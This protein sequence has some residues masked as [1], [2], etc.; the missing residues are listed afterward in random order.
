MILIA[1]PCVIENENIIFR[2]CDFLVKLTDKYK[3]EL[4]FKS[5]YDK[6]NRSSIN[7]FRGPGIEVGYKIFEKLKREFDVKI[8][9]DVH[10]DSEV[11]IIK[12]VVDIIQIPAFLCRQTDLLKTAAD[13]KKIINVKKGQFMAPW[14]MKDVIEKLKYFNAIDILITERGFTFGYNNLVV[15][16]RSFPILKSFGYKVIFDA[17]HS[18]QLPSKGKNS[19]DGERHFVPYLSRAAIACGV[20]GLFMEV[21]PDPEN[22]LCD[23]KNMVDFVMLENVLNDALAIEKVLWK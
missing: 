9:T 19:S 20:D 7:S 23:G 13:S 3:I 16:Y 6:A 1:G 2:T 11:D 10:R 18:V 21:H 15:D 14:D 4:Y 5:S 22:A 8:L 12:D 17:T